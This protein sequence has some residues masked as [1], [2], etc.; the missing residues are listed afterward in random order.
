MFLEILMRIAKFIYSTREGR[1]LKEIE[2]DRMDSM[3]AGHDANEVKVSQAF[4]SFINDRVRPFHK[5][6]K[7]EYNSFREHKLHQRDVE[8]VFTM[9]EKALKEIYR[10]KSL[11]LRDTAKKPHNAD[12]MNHENCVQ[13]FRGDLPLKLPLKMISAAFGMSKSTVVNEF[14][15]NSLQEYHKMTY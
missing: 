2:K 1:T 10:Q 6:N 5:D 15:R 14:E 3:R 8:V 7:I 11:E 13:L 4:Y 12:W 9:N